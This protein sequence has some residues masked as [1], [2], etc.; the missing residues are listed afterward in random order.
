MASQLVQQQQQPGESGTGQA[1]PLTMRVPSALGVHQ[2]RHVVYIHA[3][4]TATCITCL[5]CFVS[6]NS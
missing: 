3:E 6:P 5:P 4:V 2:A 1:A